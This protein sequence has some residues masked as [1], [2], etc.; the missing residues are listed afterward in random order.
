MNTRIACSLAAALALSACGPKEDPQAAA[1]A[2]AAETA[3][4]QQ[5]ADAK[6]KEFDDAYARS[7][8]KLAR[9]YGDSLQMDY[10]DSAAAKRIAPKLEQARSHIRDEENQR[11]RIALWAYQTQPAK[12][13]TQ[14]S[15]AIY[16]K[17]PVDT[18]GGKRPVRLIFRDHPEWGKSAYLVLEKGD[19][20]CYSG[21]KVKVTL[22]DGKPKSMAASR[23]KTDEAIAMF[24][25]DHRAL[26]RMAQQAKTA[27]AIEFPVKAGGTRTAV[28]ETGG[29]DKD[30]L[31]AWR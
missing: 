24:I 18:G 8:W 19:F 3:R 4:V 14:I 11:R 29:A 7:D 22:D 28:F 5:I 1:K 2:A 6:E 12:G 10:P 17:D 20:D 9:G 25:T 16:S 13:G 26:W 15:A 23:P 21:C 30:K 31:P 27:M